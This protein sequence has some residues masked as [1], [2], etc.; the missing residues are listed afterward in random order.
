M[1][2]EQNEQQ[3]EEQQEPKGQ[4]QAPPDDDDGDYED[5]LYAALKNV[6]NSLDDDGEDEE[7]EGEGT[8]KPKAKPVEE[9][10]VEELKAAFTKQ[11]DTLRAVVQASLAEREEKNAIQVWNGFLESASETEKVV[12]KSMAFEVDDKAGM[13]RQIKQV[14]ATAAEMEKLIQ[15]EVDRRAGQT[16]SSLKTHY[17]IL[18]PEPDDNI[19]PEV[20]DKEDIAKGD[21]AK[22]IARRFARRTGS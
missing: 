19:A 13:E 1:A 20:R 22:V 5:V 6:Y 8:P 12:A 2:D 16:K 11:Q 3:Q 15:A 4:E 14:K 9:M 17:G 7:D 18:T 21:Y 10:S